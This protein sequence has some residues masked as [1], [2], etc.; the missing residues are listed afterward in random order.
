MWLWSGEGYWIVR[1]LFQRALALLY[2]LAFLVAANQFRPLAGEDGLLPLSRY[3]EN[4]SFRER[5]SLFYFYPSDRVIAIAAW[6]GVGLSLLA[7]VATPYWLPDPYATPAS[8][9]L[10][11][12]LWL[13]YLSFVNAGQTFY[14]YGWESMLLETGFL[15]VFLGAGGVAPPFVV[16]VLLQWVLFRNM[17]GAGLIKLRGDECWRDLTCMEY[18][19][20]T[21]PIPNPVSWFAHHRSKAFHRLE[22]L[23][24]HVVELAV[25]FLYFAP[26]PAAALA[27]V[28]TIGF[29]GW[30]MITGNFAWLNALTI[31]LA[32]ATFSDGVLSTVLPVT[33]PAVA[34]TPL[35]LEVAAVLVALAVV[36]LSVR[37]TMNMLSEGQVMNTSFD[38]LHLVNTYGAFGSI[39]RDRYELVIEGTA[40]EVLTD[41]TKWR[42]YEFKGKPTDP[43]QRPRQVAPYHLRL[44]WQLWFAAMSP[45]PYRSPWFPRLLGKLLEGDEATLD[46]LAENPF[47][48]PPEY[49]RA[50]R[51][52]YGY[53]T[54]EE[55]DET[56]RWWERERVGTYVEPVSR[57]DFEG[58]G[59]RRQRLR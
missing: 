48:E 52:R 7:L 41:G 25:P 2:L 49:V 53:T 57:E 28:A 29:Q 42:A 55:R 17:F 10:W 21:Q 1:L 38:P 12:G 27:G 15:A 47:E 39:T 13:L 45:S 6:T 44:D 36:G 22:T 37:P 16:F 23:G 59:R 35:Y 50:I 26:Q 24:N 54:P 8:M 32:I 11:A 30:L 18:H 5:P 40:D 33:A 19:Y 4:A 3:V 58:R 34:P 14:G 20:E 51:Y 9:A 46:L 56:G 43:E 31:V